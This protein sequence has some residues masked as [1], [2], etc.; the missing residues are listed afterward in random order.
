MTQPTTSTLHGIPGVEALVEWFGRMP[1]FHD[2]ELLEISFSSKGAGVLRVHAWN[3]TDEV[4]AQG[5]FVLDRH[6]VVTLAL[7]G[8]STIDCAD[9]HMVPG[10]IFDLE[11]T[12]VDEHFRIEWS[13]SYGV[14]GSVTAKQVQITLEPGKPE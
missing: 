7:D 8:V 6:V 11:I 3:M 12:K 5:Y 10:I 1:R 2:A 9:F 14:T 13:A 4:D